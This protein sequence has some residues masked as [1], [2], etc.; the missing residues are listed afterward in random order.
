MATTDSAKEL[1][2]LPLPNVPDSPIREGAEEKSGV[3]AIKQCTL[4][5]DCIYSS[6]LH[7]THQKHTCKNA[8]TRGACLHDI[9][10]L[11]GKSDKAPQNVA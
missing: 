2:L 9:V 3:N 1:S 6:R 10:E 7:R 8:A 11:E 5:S 4:F